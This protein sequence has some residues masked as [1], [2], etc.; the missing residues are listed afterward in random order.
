MALWR[1]GLG[2]IGALLI[3]AVPMASDSHSAP[4]QGLAIDWRADPA[5]SKKFVVSVSGFDA[6]TS[7]DL[8]RV[9][10]DLAQWQRLLSV[11]AQPQER[12]SELGLPAMLG[13][14]R[15]S[16]DSLQFEPQFPLDPGIRYRAAFDPTQCPGGRLPRGLRTAFFELP[17]ISKTSNTVV[18]RV[19]PSAGVLP[20]NLLKFYLHF[21]APMSGG[22]IYDFIHLRDDRGKDVDLPFL[23]VNE[24]LWDPT[25]TRLTLFIDPGRIKR[26]LRPLQE[27]GP[28]LEQG[29]RYR[30][31]IE[32]RWQDAAG[33][34][35]KKSYQK[36][37]RV[38]PPARDSLDPARWTIQT[39]KAGT[40][41]PLRISFPKP[42]DQALAQRLI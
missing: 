6:R 25:M 39:P 22:H 31:V 17:P 26:G 16:G 34:P 4:S 30:L 19:Y 11:Y 15:I 20:E 18:T 8:R 35:L 40:R 7:Q 36:S 14:Y 5:D 21:S 23:E 12:E 27:M 28:A 42:L 24:E 29:K 9:Q 1:R 2:L 33:N 13:T 32:R 10:W 3:G 37:F 41:A 38:G